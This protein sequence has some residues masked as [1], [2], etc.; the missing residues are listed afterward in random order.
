M[1]WWDGI[2]SNPI[3]GSASRLVLHWRKDSK[4]FGSYMRKLG[5]KSSSSEWVCICS[6]ILLLLS[7]YVSQDRAHGAFCMNVLQ[8]ECRHLVIK[9]NGDY[10]FPI[11]SCLVPKLAE[12][13]QSGHC[14]HHEKLRCRQEFGEMTWILYCFLLSWQLVSIAINVY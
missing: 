10:L 12:A 2:S 14:H 7:E 9:R 1:A 8:Q 6:W 4:L 11:F 3:G 13:L 5:K